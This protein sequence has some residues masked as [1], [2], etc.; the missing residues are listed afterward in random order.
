MEDAA[1]QEYHPLCHL[2]IKD[3]SGSAVCSFREALCV[4]IVVS[5]L[6][7]FLWYD[8]PIHGK[9]NSLMKYSQELKDAMLKRMLPSNSESIARISREEGIS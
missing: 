3:C 1:E 9:E 2:I 8:Q 6:E 5:E 4:T 7:K